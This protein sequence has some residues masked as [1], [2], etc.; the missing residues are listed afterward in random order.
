MGLCVRGWFPILSHWL[1]CI[2]YQLFLST[3]AC[4]KAAL[5]LNEEWPILVRWGPHPFSHLLACRNVFDPQ[6]TNIDSSSFSFKNSLQAC[7]RNLPNMDGVVCKTAN[8]RPILLLSSRSILIT[9]PIPM[10]N[11]HAL[12]SQPRLID[13]EMEPRN[14]SSANPGNQL[15]AVVW[16]CP[17]KLSPRALAKVRVSCTWPKAFT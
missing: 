5:D 2:Q 12:L 8:F 1:I 16:G 3:C 6:W 9:A 11:L 13:K 17:A 7:N 4:L 14:G 10:H 15:F